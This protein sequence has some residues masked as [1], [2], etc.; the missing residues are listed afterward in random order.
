MFLLIHWVPVVYLLEW[1]HS[2]NSWKT[3]SWRPYIWKI[4]DNRADN[5]IVLS[6]WLPMGPVGVLGI[7]L[8][9]RIVLEN[10]SVAKAIEHG[11]KFVYLNGYMFHVIFGEN[12]CVSDKSGRRIPKLSLTAQNIPAKMLLKVLNCAKGF[13]HFFNRVVWTNLLFFAVYVIYKKN[14]SFSRVVFRFFQTKIANS[15]Y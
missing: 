3:I 14:Y 5:W 15:V 9:V 6:S 1:I 4:W 10:C 12:V 2:F 8:A 13:Y 7:W 11:L